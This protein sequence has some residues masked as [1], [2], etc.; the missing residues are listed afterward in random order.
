MV[1]VYFGVYTKNARLTNEILL[2][3]LETSVFQAPDAVFSWFVKP[4]FVYGK[5]NY[6]QRSLR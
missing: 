5:G 6:F 1:H 4:E 3:H 2:Y